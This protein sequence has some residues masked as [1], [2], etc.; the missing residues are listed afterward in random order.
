[1]NAFKIVWI[2]QSEKSGNFQIKLQRA[3][4][5]TDEFGT[6]ETQETYYVWRKSTTLEAGKSI[7]V[8]PTEWKIDVKKD[9]PVKIDGVEKLMTLK[10]LLR[11]L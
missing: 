2:R 7:S 5:E 6:V 8:N 9:V 1:M 10:T 3:V 4:S 11:K